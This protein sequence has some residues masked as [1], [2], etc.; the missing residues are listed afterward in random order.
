MEAVVWYVKVSK[1]CLSF[2]PVFLLLGISHTEVIKDVQ[3][4][5]WNIQPQ[6]NAFFCCQENSWTSMENFAELFKRNPPFFP[7]A[8]TFKTMSHYWLCWSTSFLKLKLTYTIFPTGPLIWTLKTKIKRKTV[9]VLLGLSMGTAPII[10][11]HFLTIN[12]LH[13]V[14]L[15]W[16][17]L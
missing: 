2:D 16:F 14:V 15:I 12:C 8:L 5:G 7:S 11:R 9:T 10:V 4:Y 17:F 1:L 13:V 3:R 6:W